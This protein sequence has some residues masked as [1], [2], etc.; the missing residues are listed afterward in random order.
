ME[1]RINQDIRSTEVRL[2]GE[3]GDQMGVFPTHLA[4]RKAEEE[5]L[6][7][8]EVSPNAKPPVCKLMDYGRFKFEQQKKD[9]ERRRNTKTVSV[10]TIKLRPKIGEADLNTKIHQLSKF[11][12]DGHKAKIVV[13][14]KGREI[15]HKELGKDLLD[16]VSNSISGHA[17]IEVPPKMEGRNLMMLVS[18]N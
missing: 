1:I 6:D 7:L 4:L 12:M 9:R 17:N 8:V 15:T 10:K 5:D 16:R 14:F 13:Q 3:D 18:P 11:L 2:V